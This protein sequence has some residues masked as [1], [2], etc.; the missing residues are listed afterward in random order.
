MTLIGVGKDSGMSKKVGWAQT[1]SRGEH[2]RH[3]MQEMWHQVAYR[4]K[5]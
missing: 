5:E 1:R 3:G 4:Q 2:I